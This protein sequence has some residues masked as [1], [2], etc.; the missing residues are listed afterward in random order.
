VV[1]T[2]PG[3]FD[4]F[5]SDED[6]SST[7]NFYHSHFSSSSG[8][9]HSGTD[10][11]FDRVTNLQHQFQTAPLVGLAWSGTHGV[12]GTTHPTVEQMNY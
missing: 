10:V 3:S 6:S 5:A 4:I 12:F 7:W 2:A 8:W 1:S 9:T 11:I